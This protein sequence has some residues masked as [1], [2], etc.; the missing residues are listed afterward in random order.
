MTINKTYSSSYS[1]PCIQCPPAPPIRKTMQRRLTPETKI[2]TSSGAPSLIQKVSL[3]QLFP[4][5]KAPCP[6]PPPPSPPHRAHIQIRFIEQA[7][8]LMSSETEFTLNAIEEEVPIQEPQTPPQSCWHNLIKRI[9]EL[10]IWLLSGCPSSQPRTTDS[11]DQMRVEEKTSVDQ[12]VDNAELLQR[13]EKQMEERNRLNAQESASASE[14]LPAS[15][16][17]IE[18][19]HID[20]LQPK[21]DKIF[22]IIDKLRP[23]N[24]I[25]SAN[26]ITAIMEEMNQ[27]KKTGILKNVNEPAI[28]EYFMNANREQLQTLWNGS[29]IIKNVV[30]LVL[31]TQKSRMT[32]RLENK[33]AREPNFLLSMAY[34]CGIKEISQQ[35]AWVNLVRAGNYE[36]AIQ[37]ALNPPLN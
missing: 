31:N 14:V 18:Q 28:I 36:T 6:T 15:S 29:V 3:N 24:L 4:V 11:T 23:W 5:P 27:A 17:T 12:A 37:Q 32:R 26:A 35:T 33:L 34:A 8:P 13:L 22:G 21:F 9:Q 10:V 20:F 16:P 7:K 19:A 25:S 1:V 2:S 30:L